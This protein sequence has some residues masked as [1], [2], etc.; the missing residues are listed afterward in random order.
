MKFKFLI[1]ILLFSFSS[2]SQE[3]I[4][5]GKTETIYSELLKEDRILEIHLPKNYGESD[6]IYPVLYL[7][8]SY[9]N[10]SHAV[11]SVEYLH[12]N[13]L[14]PEMIIVGIRNTHRNRDLTPES[15]ELVQKNGKDW[16]Q[17]VEPIIS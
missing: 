5:I 17:P 11:G 15:P 12:L 1:I 2:Y 10:F 6:K 14:I 7:L 9:F 8:D 16:E 13:R 4:T 3:A